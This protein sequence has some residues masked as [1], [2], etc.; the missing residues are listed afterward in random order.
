MLVCFFILIKTITLHLLLLDEVVLA[1]LGEAP[2]RHPQQVIIVEAGVEGVLV[3]G[4]ILGIDLVLI[5][6]S[7]LNKMITSLD[8]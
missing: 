8:N 3:L 5:L 7:T 2:H 6:C 4:V 1:L